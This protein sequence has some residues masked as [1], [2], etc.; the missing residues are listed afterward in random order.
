MRAFW[1]YLLDGT[2]R[3]PRWAVPGQGTSV[4]SEMLSQVSGLPEVSIYAGQAHP[5]PVDSCP[6]RSW[7]YHFSLPPCS[8]SVLSRMPPPPGSHPRHTHTHTHTP[9]RPCCHITAL[10]RCRVNVRS[11]V[12]QGLELNCFLTPW[13]PSQG[14]V[15]GRK[16]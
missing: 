12:W 11:F 6:F 1:F 10:S 2:P 8:P 13:D 5:L 3:S 7:T 15:Q 16:C 14:L 9:P 4:V